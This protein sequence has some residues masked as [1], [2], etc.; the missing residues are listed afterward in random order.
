VG[1]HTWFE[2]DQLSIHA[3]V[4]DEHA[5]M[6]PPKEAQLSGSTHDPIALVDQLMVLLN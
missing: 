5:L 2:S 1:V 6:K 3:R 4:F